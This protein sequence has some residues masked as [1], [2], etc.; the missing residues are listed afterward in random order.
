MFME[1]FSLA[2][3]AYRSLDR[4]TQHKM[5]GDH[6]LILLWFVRKVTQAVGGE[7]SVGSGWAT[8]RRVGIV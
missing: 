4:L 1:S 6:Y 7:V 5:H 8:C 3:F 2:K